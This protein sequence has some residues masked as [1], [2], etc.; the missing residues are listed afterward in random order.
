M[1]LLCGDGVHA[2]N[3]RA[4]LELAILASDMLGLTL[5][6]PWIA[7]ALKV[8]LRCLSSTLAIY[9]KV[10]VFIIFFGETNYMLV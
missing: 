1:V 10:L 3:R 7:D 8:V 6:S 2:Q 4:L 5:D 9:L